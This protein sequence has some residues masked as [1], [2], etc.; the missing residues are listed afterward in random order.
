MVDITSSFTPKTHASE[1]QADLKHVQPGVTEVVCPRTHKAQ[2]SHVIGL[3][4]LSRH[5]VG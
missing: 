5:R 1:V 3:R 2:G 4:N